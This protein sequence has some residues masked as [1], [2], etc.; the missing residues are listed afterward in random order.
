MNCVTKTEL[1]IEIAQ[2][3]SYDRGKGAKTAHSQRVSAARKE[4]FQW[5]S[6]LTLKSHRKHN[7]S[8]Y[9]DRGKGRY[10]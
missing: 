7:G 6:K 10:R 9:G 2:F 3:L 5:D 8:D 1:S 4:N